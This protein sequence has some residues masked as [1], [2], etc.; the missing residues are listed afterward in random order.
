VKDA[1]IE[2]RREECVL[3]MGQSSNDAAAKVAQTKLRKEERAL[4]MEQRRNYA[5]MKDVQI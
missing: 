1:P 2:L 3:D 5:T 4:G